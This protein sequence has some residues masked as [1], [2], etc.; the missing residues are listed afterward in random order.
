VR[1]FTTKYALTAGIGE[2]ESEETDADGLISDGKRFPTYYRLGKDC[3]TTREE[4]ITDARRRRMQ[5]VMAVKKQL[6]KL[7]AMIF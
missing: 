6:A 2:I 4:A 7:E 3:F 5:K 1:V